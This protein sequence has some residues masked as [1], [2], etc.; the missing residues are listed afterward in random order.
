MKKV[1]QHIEIPLFN[2][3]YKVIV[4]YGTPEHLNKL[5]KAY[6]YPKE[7][8]KKIFKKNFATCIHEDGKDPIIIFPSK[9]KTP[10]EIGLIAH[11]AV[12]A[13]DFIYED[14]EQGG[15]DELFAHSVGA[16]VRETLLKLK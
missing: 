15:V 7:N 16:I 12:H 8:I 11:E 9:P 10:Y 4:A 1:K 3:E 6:D 13:I 5:L 2:T 14:I